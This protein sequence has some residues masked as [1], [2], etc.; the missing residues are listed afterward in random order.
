MN[1]IDRERLARGNVAKLNESAM[2]EAMALGP[3]IIGALQGLAEAV[4]IQNRTTERWIE[5]A[6]RQNQATERMLQ[7]LDKV[8]TA[9]D[10]LDVTCGRQADELEG[11]R[12]HRAKGGN[13]HAADDTLVD[14]ER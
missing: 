3:Q 2:A 11:L 14:V 6:D 12:L 4:T 8:C 10:R 9:L 1:K 7:M 5:S 13:G